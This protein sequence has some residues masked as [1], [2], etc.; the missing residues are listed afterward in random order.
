MKQGHL[1]LDFLVIPIERLHCFRQTYTETTS[2]IIHTLLESLD[3]PIH[4]Q[5]QRVYLVEMD[6]MCVLI[7]Y[8]MSRF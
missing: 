4:M 2:M 7:V 6:S 1:V 3:F 5:F 8:N